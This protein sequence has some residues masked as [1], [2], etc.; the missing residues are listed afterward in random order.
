MCWKWIFSVKKIKKEEASVCASP[1]HH[2]GCCFHR[3]RSELLSSVLTIGGRVNDQKL[4]SFQRRHP[5]GHLG[6]LHKQ[7]EGTVSGRT[8]GAACAPETPEEKGR[9]SEQSSRDGAS[10]WDG[11]GSRSQE[12]RLSSREPL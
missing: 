2:E 12:P 8:A 3:I 9:A 7:G 10:I 6:Y 5:V 1:E 11:T 4:L